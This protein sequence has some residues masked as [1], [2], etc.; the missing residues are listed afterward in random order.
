MSTA[1]VTMPDGRPV[2]VSPVDAPPM[3]LGQ[4]PSGFGLNMEAM[5]KALVILEDDRWLALQTRFRVAYTRACRALLG[6]EDVQKEGA[7][8]KA[9]EFKKKSAWRT[10]AKHF[11]VTTRVVGQ[12][13][14]D[15]VG[16]VEIVWVTVE[17]RS[18]WGHSTEA[19]GACSTDEERGRRVITLADAV[20]TAE[21]R[22]TNRAISNLIAMGEVSYEE[23]AKN[24]AAQGG[25][26]DITLEEAKLWKFPWKNPAKYYGKPMGNLSEIMLRNVRVGVLKELRVNPDKVS[27]LELKRVCDLLIEDI[28]EEHATDNAEPELGAERAAMP[29][30]IAPIVQSDDQ[31]Y[32]DPKPQEAAVEENQATRE[33]GEEPDED[34]DGQPELIRT[35]KARRDTRIRD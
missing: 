5:E 19:V 6:P 1:V 15:V 8:T 12:P 30:E 35:P 2:G 25:P 34:E 13:K 17:G 22:A 26:E 29:G 28:E 10:L 11:G 21:T 24:Q 31:P 9:R 33:P 18:A 27:L 7:G 4:A 23:I 20:A 32:D 14:W 3:A 16:D